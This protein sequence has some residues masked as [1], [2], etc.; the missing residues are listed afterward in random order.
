MLRLGKRP[1]QA[2]VGREGQ[3]SALEDRELGRIAVDREH[4][5]LSVDGAAG[6][7]RTHAV[8]LLDLHHRGVL[9]QRHVLGQRGGEALG[10]AGG[11]EEPPARRIERHRVIGGPERLAE[12]CGVEPAIGLAERFHRA[13]EGLEDLRAPEVRDGGVIL[14][15]MGVA[16]VDPVLRH[17]RVEMVD[18][19][20]AEADV[21]MGARELIERAADIVRQVDGEAGIAPG[22]AFANLVRVQQHDVVVGPVLGQ[23][24]RRG[25]AGE[26]R[27]HHQPIGA[28]VALERRR[29]RTRRQDAAP[30][31][32]GVFLG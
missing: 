13:C 10:E 31:V 30:P 27:A 1:G 2:A 3:E 18:R 23:P 19:R 20:P 7:Y 25:E 4:H 21:A 17:A 8:P 6:G 28:H 22:R 5:G 26:P 29:R 32:G 11:V 12:F 9:V 16:A 15:A 24:A 14:A